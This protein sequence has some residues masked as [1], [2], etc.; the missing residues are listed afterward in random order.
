MIDPI[1]TPAAVF[2]FQTCTLCWSPVMPGWY[3]SLDLYV[4]EPGYHARG[5][6]VEQVGREVPRTHAPRAKPRT[7]IIGPFV[8]KLLIRLP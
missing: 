2:W 1:T 6:I 3:N 7:I 8:P 5:P 4:P